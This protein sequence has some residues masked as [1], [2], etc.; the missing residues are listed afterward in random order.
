MI[1]QNNW[2][3]VDRIYG[4]SQVSD[5]RWNNQQRQNDLFHYKSS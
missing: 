2:P 5:D 4:I 3:E 1:E